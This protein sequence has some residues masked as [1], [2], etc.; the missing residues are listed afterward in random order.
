MGKK[1][2]Y[3]VMIRHHRG[4]PAGGG[5]PW[6]GHC[7]PRA[8]GARHNPS[9]ERPVAGLDIELVQARV[10]RPGVA[11]RRPAGQTWCTTWRRGISLEM[12]RCA[13]VE[14]INVVGRERC[15]QPA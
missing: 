4:K 5:E 10:R 13:E 1:G 2:L 14:A 6:R 7:W 8:A 11:A 15:G 9:R 12:D 3:T